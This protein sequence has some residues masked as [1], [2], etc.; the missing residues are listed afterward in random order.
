[1]KKKDT[2]LVAC[3]GDFGKIEADRSGRSRLH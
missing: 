1:M 3:H 2:L